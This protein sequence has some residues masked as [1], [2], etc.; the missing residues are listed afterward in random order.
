MKTFEVG[1]FHIFSLF[2]QRFFHLI[3]E[4]INVFFDGGRYKRFFH[5]IWLLPTLEEDINVFFNE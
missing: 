1:Y 4:D 3:V 2:M 5:F